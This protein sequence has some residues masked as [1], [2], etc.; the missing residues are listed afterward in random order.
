MQPLMGENQEKVK[1]NLNKKVFSSSQKV[2]WEEAVLHYWE[3][4]PKL[5][6]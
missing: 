1:A 2:T 6:L 3:G 4:V 5:V